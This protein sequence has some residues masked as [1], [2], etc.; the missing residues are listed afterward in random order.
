MALGDIVKTGHFEVLFG[1]KGT[2]TLV[3]GRAAAVDASG[4]FIPATASTTTP[5][6]I[7]T[8]LTEVRSG[9]TYHQLIIAGYAACEM[10]GVVVP[11]KVVKSDAVGKLITATITTDQDKYVGVY[12]R[13]RA[14]DQFN[15]SSSADTNE[16][17]VF[18]T[19]WGF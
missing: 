17:V 8:G 13:L 6:G 12:P 11:N 14:D 10:G 7:V 18:L 19:G 1:R 2:G 3:A 15:P 5:H 9:V 16:G 4:D